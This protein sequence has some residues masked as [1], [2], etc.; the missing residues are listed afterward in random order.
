MCQSYNLCDITFCLAIKI[1]T[2]IFISISTLQS[3]INLLITSA[4]VQLS[5]QLQQQQLLVLI[6]MLV[7]CLSLGTNTKASS[8]M[9]NVHGSV[10]RRIL[11][12]SAEFHGKQRHKIGPYSLS[13]SAFLSLLPHPPLRVWGSRGYLGSS[14]NSGYFISPRRLGQISKRLPKQIQLLN[15]YAQDTNQKQS[16]SHKILAGDNNLC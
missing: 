2:Q 9:Q 12:Q 4:F 14:P 5:C 3:E 15:K 13:F 6:R 8:I 11:H 16:I 1:D 10:Y 7:N